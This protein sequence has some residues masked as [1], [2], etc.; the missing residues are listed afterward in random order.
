MR[1]PTAADHWWRPAEMRYPYLLGVKLAAAECNVDVAV[2]V[3]Y[4]S[5]PTSIC[6]ISLYMTALATGAFASNPVA[7]RRQRG[8]YP[9]RI[10]G[11]SA[12]GRNVTDN[13]DDSDDP[14]IDLPCDGSPADADEPVGKF[15]ITVNRRD[16][17]RFEYHS[18]RTRVQRE[19]Q[20]TQDIWPSD[21]SALEADNRYLAGF[22]AS[23]QELVINRLFSTFDHLQL[24]AWTLESM[25]GAM[26]FSQFRHFGRHWRARLR[27]TG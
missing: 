22:G 25:S 7:C 2:R 14:A 8:R 18:L 16:W 23:F 10:V 4:E 1:A 27:P 9:V 24:A 19:L 6:R 3:D 26:I 21:G 17:E 15:T 20:E 12:Y 5:Q 13:R 11:A